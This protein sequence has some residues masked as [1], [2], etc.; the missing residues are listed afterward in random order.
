[1]VTSSRHGF[2]CLSNFDKKINACR[3]DVKKQHTS[4]WILFQN[5]H[6]HKAR[7]WNVELQSKRKQVDKTTAT[8]HMCAVRLDI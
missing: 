1:M 7:D 8:R 4:S 5:K 2:D 6:E 3:E